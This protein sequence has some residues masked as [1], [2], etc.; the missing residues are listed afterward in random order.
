MQIR[1]NPFKRL[2]RSA[3]TIIGVATFFVLCEM[4]TRLEI[5]PRAYLPYA[6][7]VLMK[8][9]DLLQS[10]QFLHHTIVTTFTWLSALLIGTLVSVPIGIALGLSETSYK[11]AS[12]IIEFM[13]PIPAVALIPLGIMLWGQGLTMKLILTVWASMWPILYNTVYGVHDI[14]EVAVQTAKCLGFNRYAIVKNVVLPSSGPFIFNGIRISASIALIVVI[15]T[16]LLASS[17]AG[18]GAFILFASVN[19]G[20]AESVLAGSAIAGLIGVLANSVLNSI[21]S[22]YFSWRL[23]NSAQETHG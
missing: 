9:I 12:P 14:D 21:D 19:A 3:N 13:R 10:P 8:I 4:T 7:D 16:E 2:M 6:S 15:G 11:L 5:V 17:D 1:L 22:R 20:N 18:I 23:A